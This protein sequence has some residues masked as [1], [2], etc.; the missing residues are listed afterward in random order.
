MKN[1]DIQSYSNRTNAQTNRCHPLSFRFHPTP[2]IPQSTISQKWTPPKSR[3]C[4]DFRCDGNCRLCMHRSHLSLVRLHHPAHFL[5]LLILKSTPS[6]LVCY[7]P[8]SFLFKQLPGPCCA[9]DR[10]LII[11]SYRKSSFRSGFGSVSVAFLVSTLHFSPF[12]IDRI[13]LS[14]HWTF[15]ENQSTHH[16]SLRASTTWFRTFAPRLKTRN[17]R[18][19]HC[20]V[21]QSPFCPLTT[22]FHACCLV[23]ICC[24]PVMYTNIV[25]RKLSTW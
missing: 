3:S 21:P 20:E 17:R 22:C 13:S 10:Q 7:H 11:V 12:L 14:P 2:S 4:S 18:I 9:P 1:D 15:Q 23:L 24:N 25:Y 6:P 5:T 16:Q 8:W 19:F